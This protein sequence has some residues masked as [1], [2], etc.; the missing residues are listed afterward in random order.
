MDEK[1]IE[2]GIKRGICL[3]A[4]C[5]CEQ[6]KTETSILSLKKEELPENR[7]KFCSI[8]SHNSTDHKFLRKLSLLHSSDDKNEVNRGE[9]M[10]LF[11][12]M[13][14][15]DGS[16]A[17]FDQGLD[18]SSGPLLL[19]FSPFSSSS[20][21]SE[22]IPFVTS[23]QSISLPMNVMTNKNSS[24]RKGE[25]INN[26]GLPK[27]LLQLH[28][29]SKVKSED[30]SDDDYDFS[31][32]DSDDDDEFGDE[33]D[34]NITLLN[35]MNNSNNSD[36]EKTLDK[37]GEN[38]NRLKLK[39]IS[40]LSNLQ[41]NLNDIPHG[42]PLNSPSYPLF[43]RKFSDSPI[44]RPHNEDKINSLL[45]MKKKSLTNL[46]PSKKKLIDDF[47]L[48]FNKDNIMVMNNNQGDGQ[49]RNLKMDSPRF[50]KWTTNLQ[51]KINSTQQ[52]GIPLDVLLFREQDLNLSVPSLFLLLSQHITKFGYYSFILL[53]LLFY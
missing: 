48:N 6:Y 36:E 33:Y 40:N 42:S 27:E 11:L 20:D 12:N 18:D 46:P 53:L 21:Q 14:K 1:N 2:N 39:A 23:T 19:K 4:N 25:E 26:N 32:E 34:S 7:E 10:D 3:Q 31:S 22:E 52:F 37:K 8:C 44:R 28:S 16:M 9:E 50:A 15:L 45:Q 5:D 49:N 13:E 29:P 41:L 17:L 43:Q 51:K 30:S 24:S 38:E 47:K 35:F